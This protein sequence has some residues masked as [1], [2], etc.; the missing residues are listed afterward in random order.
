MRRRRFERLACFKPAVLVCASMLLAAGLPGCS[1]GQS[2]VWSSVRML[3][4]G[5]SGAGVDQP[6]NPRYRYLRVTINGVAVL[7][8]LGYV[9]EPSSP[10]PVQVWYSASGE[11][12]RLRHGRLA[13]LVGTPVEWRDV[14]WPAGVPVWRDV[15]QAPSAY[16]RMLDEMPGYRLGAVE[17]LTL[18]PIVKPKDVAWAGVVPPDVRW[19]R[20][21]T[22]G[23]RP[24][25]RYGV[26]VG[27]QTAEPVY[28]EQCLAND[29]C[30]TWQ[31]WPAAR[32]PS[33]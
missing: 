16:Q 8:V 18:E 9:D 22:T 29:F 23:Q 3:A 5:P 6:L 21:S 1:S 25:A 24:S 28:G 2:A 4:S 19:Y 14:R 32:M 15:G 31:S 13:G 30:L 20:E 12:L 33:P 10:S 11:V 7:M 26:L 17:S 27:A